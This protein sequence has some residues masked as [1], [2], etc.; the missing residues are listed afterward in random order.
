MS[1]HDSLGQWWQY[2]VAGVSTLAVAAGSHLKLRDRVKTLEVR[3]GV[4]EAKGEVLDETHDTVIRMESKVTMLENDL[5]TSS[6]AFARDM[7]GVRDFM[8]RLEKALKL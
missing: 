8:A 7:R 4:I 3:Q 6:D 5:R 1:S 2:I